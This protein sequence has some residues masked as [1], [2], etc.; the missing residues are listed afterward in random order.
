M[1]MMDFS[2]KAN[3][4]YRVGQETPFVFNV[5]AQQFAGQSIVTES[6][7][8]WHSLLSPDGSGW[9]FYGVL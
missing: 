1:R 9:R 4:G 7:K 2:V 6:L 8:V 5:E 3:L